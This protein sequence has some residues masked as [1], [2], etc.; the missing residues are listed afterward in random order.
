MD[1]LVHRA[2]RLARTVAPFLALVAG[3]AAAD[4]TRKPDAPFIP[5]PPAVVAEMLRVASVGPSDVVYD[6]GSGDGRI[7]IAAAKM[8]GAR[9][10][11]IEI[12]PALVAR[13]EEA[14]ERAGV[15]DRVRFVR[16]DLFRADLSEA[17]VVALYLLPAMNHA[18]RPKL[19][20]LRPGTRVVSHDFAIGDWAPDHVSEVQ[21]KRVYLWIVGSRLGKPR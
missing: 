1:S 5:T 17:T 18:L 4:A 20:G 12:D 16:Q 9:A 19:E 2:R 7:V 21:G 14:A 3:A 8:H 11:G 13:A 6:L 10:V 15:A